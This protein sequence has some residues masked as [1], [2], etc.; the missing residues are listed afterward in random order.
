MTGLGLWRAVARTIVGLVRLYLLWREDPSDLRPLNLYPVWEGDEGLNYWRSAQYD[1]DDLE[2]MHAAL[3]L[4]SILVLRNSLP[5][6]E[7]HY[8]LR[9]GIRLFHVAMRASDRPTDE[10]VD[11]LLRATDQA[12]KPM[13]AHCAGGA[14]RTGVWSFLVRL[15]VF[16]LDPERALQALGAR[17]FHLPEFVPDVRVLRR[18]ARDYAGRSRSKS[19]TSHDSGA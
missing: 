14:D 9:H 1:E 15:E 12:P 5:D 2:W 16:G 8:C 17:Y 7:A 6:W 13:L 3:G 11:S 19:L 10:T 4:R 18:W